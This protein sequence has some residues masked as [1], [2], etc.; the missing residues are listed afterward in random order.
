MFVRCC[1]I[2]KK[3]YFNSMLQTTVDFI[4]TFY[5]ERKGLPDNNILKANTGYEIESVQLDE[6]GKNW[7]LNA[8]EHFCRYKAIELAVLEAPEILEKKNYPELEKKV[9]DAVLISLQKDLGL[10]YWNDPLARLTAL[11]QNKGTIKTGF[12]DIDFKLFGGFNRKELEIICAGSGVGKSLFLQNLAIN[13]AMQKLNVV[14]ISLELSEEMISKRLDAMTTGIAIGEIIKRKEEVNEILNNKATEYGKIWVKEMAQQTKANDIIAYIEQFHLQHE[15]LP[16]LLV[17][18]YLDIMAPNNNKIDVGNISVKDKYVSEELRGIARRF[19]L[20]LATASQLTKDSANE[21][22]Y[23]Q[24]NVAGGQTKINT[25]DNALSV[26]VT[27][28]MR[29]RGEWQMQFLKTRSSGGV[30]S[31]ILLKFDPDTLRLSDHTENDGNS[32]YTGNS[33]DALKSK[34]QVSGDQTGVSGHGTGHA[35]S[36]NTLLRGGLSLRD[37]L[38]KNT[39]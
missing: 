11:E 17:V 26:M 29:Q 7:F 32:G 9:R 25:C 30:G 6:A 28:S 37:V 1:N 38:S 2:L 23:N 14:Y 15:F 39:R 34:N 10:D 13:F 21:Q 31:R 19:N 20:V 18:D 12:K 36:G 16:D 8:I 5:D 3:E 4:I 22:V 33:M 27:D 35:P 24:S